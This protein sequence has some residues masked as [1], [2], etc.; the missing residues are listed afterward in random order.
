MKKDNLM[1]MFL[2]MLLSLFL[3]GCGGGGGSS[4]TPPTSTGS[5]TTTP[6]TTTA[7]EITMVS[8]N[9]SALSGLN[10][11]GD[12]IADSLTYLNAFR[13]SAGLSTVT[14]N[15]QIA[16]A[17][18]NHA[19]YEA[20]AALVTHDETAGQPYYTAA[21]PD[22]RIQAV[23][24]TSLDGEITG[25]AF[26]VQSQI[27]AD[28]TLSITGLRDAPFH[29]ENMFYCYANAGVGSANGAQVYNSY[30]A[31]NV[32]TEYLNVDFADP[33]A[34]KPA[35]TQVVVWPFNG[36]TN[37]PT[38]WADTEAEAPAG[39]AVTNEHGSTVGY[40]VTMQGYNNAAFSAVTFTITDPT[41]FV[42]PCAEY[43]SSNNSNAQAGMA[44]QCVP[45][46][47]LA[48]N[49][50]YTVKVTATMT[51]ASFTATPFTL[52]W[53]FTTASTNANPDNA[54]IAPAL[55]TAPTQPINGLNATNTAV[56]QAQYACQQYEL[57]NPSATADCNWLA[58]AGVATGNIN[59]SVTA[60]NGSV[61]T[62]SN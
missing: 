49:T 2:G 37:V 47:E 51:N 6:P 31:S 25:S 5:G 59:G 52:T 30:Y 34:S 12:F 21:T 41:G 9:A 13:S 24:P 46:L 29:R 50:V 42:I 32:Y 58:N 33:C 38:S 20:A 39:G 57:A 60:T 55:S 1:L 53:S 62:A 18:Q 61:A 44:A 28:S 40:P 56:L 15:A 10:P 11:T 16:T 23:H 22:A 35:D 4:S 7:T 54:F 27:A 26:V 45:L 36:Q 14:N 19:N 48:A 3:A 43:D 8:P 17:A